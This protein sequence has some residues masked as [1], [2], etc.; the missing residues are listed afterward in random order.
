MSLSATMNLLVLGA[1]LH[2]VNLPLRTCPVGVLLNLISC[3][4]VLVYEGSRGTS[5]WKRIWG[6]PSHIG[7]AATLEKATV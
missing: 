1:D 2:E 3:L 6:F 5:L 4:N 7:A